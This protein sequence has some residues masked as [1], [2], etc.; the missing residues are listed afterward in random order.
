MLSK[1]LNA[2]LNKQMNTEF[3]SAYAYLSA[4]AYFE[5][6]EFGGFANF[7]KIQAAEEMQHGMKIFDYLHHAGG[8][9]ILTAVAAPKRD[10]SS[11]LHV[12]ETG[13]QNEQKLAN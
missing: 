5:E 10:F 7:F 1:K 11:P 3:F 2:A 6:E 8:S 9:A 4:A 13:L 12:F